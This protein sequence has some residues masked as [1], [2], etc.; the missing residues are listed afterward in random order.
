M[1][2]HPDRDLGHRQ[3]LR[4]RGD[5]LAV[6]RDRGHDVALARSQRLQQLPRVTQRVRVLSL[7]SGQE[8]LE[9]L[10]RFGP[11]P[12]ATA[13]GVH[14]FVARDRVHPW[15]ERLLG[16]PGVTLEVDRQQG[17]LHC[18]LDIRVPN[19]RA[20]KSA[21]RHTP[22]RPTNVLKYPPARVLI[23]RDRGGHHSRPKIVPWTLDGLLS[24]TGFASFRLPLQIWRNI[25]LE[26]RIE[27]DVTRSTNRSQYNMPQR[28]N[29]VANALQSRTRGLGETHD[30]RGS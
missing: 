19:T 23:A 13:Q 18:I 28:V 3:A 2:R 30:R 17:L 1:E 6:K 29:E 9:I 20:R 26:A 14:N 10:E 7:R 27:A 22:H 25:L 5:R 4:R 8:L 16:V 11:P 12:A 15:G 21:A 24:H